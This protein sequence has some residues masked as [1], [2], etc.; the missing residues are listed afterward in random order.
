[1]VATPS[2]V[3]VAWTFRATCPAGCR[4]RGMAHT[5]WESCLWSMVG[6]HKSRGSSG[7][8]WCYW[9]LSHLA[10]YYQYNR[11]QLLHHDDV[12]TSGCGVVFL[13]VQCKAAEVHDPTRMKGHVSAAQARCITLPWNIHDEALMSLPVLLLCS[14]L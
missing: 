6:S 2:G 1:M 3:S 14:Y 7:A 11:S 4:S 8:S 12:I 9:V 13:M 5:T 10:G